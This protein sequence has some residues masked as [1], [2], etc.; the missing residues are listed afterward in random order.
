M[1]VLTPTRK[2]T[3]TDYQDECSPS[4]LSKRVRHHNNYHLS[5]QFEQLE[6]EELMNIILNIIKEHPGV[7]QTIIKS[8]PKPTV[9]K[10]IKIVAGLEKKFFDAMP[11]SRFGICWTKNRPG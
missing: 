11:Y 7:E 2:R 6:K 10:C 5:L 9:E 4:L 1:E 3:F 8:I